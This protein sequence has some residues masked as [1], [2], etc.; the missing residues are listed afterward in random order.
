MAEIV[1]TSG[2]NNQSQPVI[3]L[4]GST[5]KKLKVALKKRQSEANPSEFSQH[6]IQ[7]KTQ[8]DA[9]LKAME[10]SSQLLAF[11][12]NSSRHQSIA[13]LGEESTRNT[14]V[15]SD[16]ALQSSQHGIDAQQTWKS[17]TPVGGSQRSHK[18]SPSP[19]MATVRPS[20][21]KESPPMQKEMN[22]KLSK[23]QDKINARQQVIDTREE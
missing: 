22:D 21:L 10:T 19:K 18:G 4:H 12:L 17:V 15:A 11:K 9:I 1:P 16:A 20:L 6:L 5:S 7:L 3:D 13:G 23:I 2:L 8:D 14:M